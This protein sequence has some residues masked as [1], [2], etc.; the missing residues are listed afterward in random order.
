MTPYQKKRILQ[1]VIPLIIL[2]IVDRIHPGLAKGLLVFATI[3]IAAYCFINDDKPWARRI[4]NKPKSW[5][6]K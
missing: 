2:A 6:M 1:L 4:L 3:S 5:W